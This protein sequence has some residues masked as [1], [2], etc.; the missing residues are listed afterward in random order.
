MI[1]EKNNKVRR[2][3]FRT[4]EEVT[5]EQFNTTPPNGGWSPKQIFEHLVRMETI[6]AKNVA[7]ELKNPNSPKAMKK[8]IAISVNRMIKVKAP[9]YT[10]PTDTYKTKEEMKSELYNSH[11]F[12]L[13]VYELSKK[14]DCHKKSLKHPVFGQIPLYQWFPFV[15]LHE[16]RHLKQLKLT[17][18]MNLDELM[19]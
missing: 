18:K 12:L 7:R 8:P 17:I 6:I 2:E 15:A 11:I 19:L 14:V 16:K 9:E 5:D 1:L 3:L 10:E 13:D 4:I